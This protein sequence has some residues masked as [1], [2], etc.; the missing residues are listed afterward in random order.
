M[1]DT[2]YSRDSA[3]SASFTPAACCCRMRS[4]AL[5][6]LPVAVWLVGSGIA[7]F[8]ASFDL[9]SWS[10][11]VD[12]V[13]VGL[14]IASATMLSN[15]PLALLTEDDL[16]KLPTA[17]LFSL[18][19]RGG[20]TVAGILLLVKLE[21]ISKEVALG[22]TLVWYVGLLV[23]ELTAIVRHVNRLFASPQASSSEMIR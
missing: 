16:A 13:S 1:I 18:V 20:L 15:F 9:L 4:V 11:A 5:L 22:A 23:I 8:V 3:D 17:L 19:L 7:V 21:W 10:I 12:F 2:T 14:L 6:F